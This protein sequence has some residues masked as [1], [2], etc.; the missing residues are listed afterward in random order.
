MYGHRTRA[1]AALRSGIELMRNVSEGLAKPHK[2]RDKEKSNYQRAF[3][4]D[5][6]TAKHSQLGQNQRQNFVVP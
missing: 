2:Y 5:Q 4:Y 6:H 1:L 3:Y